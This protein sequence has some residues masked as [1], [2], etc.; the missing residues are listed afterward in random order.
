MYIYIYI[1]TTI[2]KPHSKH[3]PNIYNIYAH[4][5]EKG[6]QN[7]TEDSHQIPREEKKKEKKK[8]YKN[9]S[10]TINKKAIMTTYR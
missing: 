8:T 1:Q 7:N 6:I 4:K 5:K 2:Q 3:K 9:K 10:K